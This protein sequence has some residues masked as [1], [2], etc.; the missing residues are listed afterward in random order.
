MR[1]KAWNKEETTPKKLIS[2]LFNNGAFVND[3]ETI[4]KCINND[5]D[6]I[7]NSEQLS[8]TEKDFCKYEND[9][10]SITLTQSCSEALTQSPNCKKLYD[11]A[12]TYVRR[13]A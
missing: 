11:T 2:C 3:F 13:K 4:E 8:F 7:P 1:L 6:E 12:K 9:P 10:A 5:K